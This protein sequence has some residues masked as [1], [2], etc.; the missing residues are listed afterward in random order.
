MGKMTSRP[1]PRLRLAGGALSGL[2][3]T[4]ALAI[5][6]GVGAGSQARAAASSVTVPSEQAGYISAGLQVQKDKVYLVTATGLINYCGGAS[7]PQCNATPDGSVSGESHCGSETGVAALCGQLIGRVA[8]GAG[9]PLGSA[10]EFTAPETGALELAVQDFG[11][12]DNNSGSFSVKIEEAPAGKIRGQ[13][14]DEDGNGMPEVLV[15]AKGKKDLA[16][17]TDFDGNYKIVVPGDAGGRYL[18]KPS[19]GRQTFKPKQLPVIVKDGKSVRAGFTAVGCPTG[20]ARDR[21]AARARP[22]GDQFRPRNGLYVY[23]GGSFDGLSPGFAVSLYYQCA[24][25]TLFANVEPATPE[26]GKFP[27]FKCTDGR[28]VSPVQYEIPLGPIKF[29]G[30]HAFQFRERF[31]ADTLLVIVRGSF[32]NETKAFIRSVRIQETRRGQPG[33]VHDDDGE[34]QLFLEDENPTPFGGR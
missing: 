27:P 14:V 8:T 28:T 13:V 30:E 3:C 16:T 20:D 1:D 24:K 18:V 23:D 29:A 21:P 7:Q 2:L 34:Y 11:N 19:S 10:V 17:K 6:L 12:R 25:K 26:Q 5:V 15:S 22:K 31:N 33:C 9:F 4:A 32:F